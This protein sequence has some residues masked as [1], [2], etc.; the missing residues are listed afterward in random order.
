MPRGLSY[1]KLE[2]MLIE[3]T[4]E[5]AENSDIGGDS[6]ADDEEPIG[7]FNLGDY[8]VLQCNF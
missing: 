5:Q 3:I 8:L 6:D 1:R 7:K 2:L 4:D